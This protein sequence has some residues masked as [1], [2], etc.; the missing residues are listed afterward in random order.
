MTSNR[1]IYGQSAR[2]RQILQL[3]Q[4]HSNLTVSQLASWLQVS[5]MTIRRDL[6]R[7]ARN[8]EV[9]RVHG[10]VVLREQDELVGKRH[11]E[12]QEQKRLIAAR[13]MTLIEADDVI[14]LDAGTTTEELAR[15]LVNAGPRPL[16]I[17]THALNIAAILMD[18]PTLAVTMAGGDVR[19]STQS[20]VGPM[21]RAFYGQVRITKAFV[22]VVGIS[23]EEGLS[24]SNFP[25]VEIKQALME[26]SGRV[27]VLADSSKLG[28]RAFSVFAPVTAAHG[29]VT[30]GDAPGDWI[31]FFRSLDIEV[32]V[33]DALS[34]TA[35]T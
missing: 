9:W 31:Q 14:G 35:L 3:L 1:R 2:S 8:G 32:F 30:D 16:T 29:I 11:R 19:A 13:C 4:Q 27:Y 24:N 25:E 17:V 12:N 23:R 26:R 34:S 22:G 7:M 6:D 15:Q 21:T 33:A 20:L 28:H 18:D 5:E 10:G